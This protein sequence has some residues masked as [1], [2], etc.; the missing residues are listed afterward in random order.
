VA[1]V[2]VCKGGVF[3]TYEVSCLGEVIVQNWYFVRLDRLCVPRN[4]ELRLRLIFEVHDLHSVGHIEVA[5]TL[6]KLLDR[7]WWKRI[8]QNVEDFCECCVVCR[9][10][11]IQHKMAT[12][13]YH[14]HFPSRPWHTDVLD[15]LTHSLD[16]NG[17]DNVL[18]VV[19]HLTRI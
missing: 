13:L 18:T 8:R 4:Y 9:R 11:K 17:F 5:R 15:F 3:G 14:V 12:T 2:G 10:S 7:L 16:S 6:F 19:D 1:A